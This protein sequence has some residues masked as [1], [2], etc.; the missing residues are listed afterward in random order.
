MKL[1]HLLSELKRRNVFKVATIYGVTAW[2]LIQIAATVFPQF[3]MPQWTVRA[4]IL[5]AAIGFPIALVLAWAYEVVPE[6]PADETLPEEV[7]PTESVATKRRIPKWIPIVIIL[8]LLGFTIWIFRKPIANAAFVD[9]KEIQDKSIAVLPFRDLSPNKDQEYLSDGMMVAILDRL[10]QVKELQTRSERSVLSYK[11]S[12]KTLT[13]IGKELAVAY[14]LEG[15]VQRYGEQ[16]RISVRLVDAKNEQPLWANQYD[17]QYANI[18]NFQN[19]IAQQIA[20]N[21]NI[22]IAPEVKQ[23]FE[24]TYTPNPEAYTKYLQGYNMWYRNQNLPKASDL[25][26]EAIAID[27]KY[28]APYAELAYM[29]IIK[30]A[31]A[32]GLNRREVIDKAQPL[33]EKAKL[34]DP[35]DIRFILINNR[36]IFYF[37]WDFKGAAQGW[38]KLS[39]MIDVANGD[40]ANSYT[41]Y[42]IQVGNFKEAEKI[43]TKAKE[44]DP[45][46]LWNWN[47]YILSLL[48]VG[49]K[50]KAIQQ[51]EIATNLFP[52]KVP[53]IVESSR[54]F[55][56]ARKY[57]KVISLLEGL[58]SAQLIKEKFG[59]PRMATHLAI[60]YHH[61]GNAKKV[62]E[63]INYLTA[64]SKQTTGGSPRFYIAMI[65]AQM[66]EK[67]LAFQWI[68]KAI[69]T[70]EIE[71]SW[72]MVEPP[73]EPLRDDPRW[74]RMLDKVGFPKPYVY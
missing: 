3:A 4:V 70:H 73:F 11:D 22:G 2:L 20:A 30:G 52:D 18:F 14:I 48:F 46:N 55:S 38:K 72:L 45:S 15:N 71:C 32:R 17:G 10:I 9:K 64:K 63:I 36:F 6:K 42:L 34:L 69:E 7:I 66:G 51:A 29:W 12:E 31:V 53:V 50:D 39:G 61:T 54:I 8:G 58:L 57:E 44:V 62:K 47:G 24:K 33:L 37:F 23:V 60:A 49:Q 27:P 26:E 1:Q 65:Y 13:E 19:E 35:N 59:F 74:E 25:L 68:E 43:S 21:L 56:Y 16:L 67:D 5:L 40:Y 41:D 28:A